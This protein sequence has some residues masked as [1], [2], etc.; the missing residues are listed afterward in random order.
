MI[1]EQVREADGVF[2]ARSAQAEN[3][4]LKYNEKELEKLHNKFLTEH[5]GSLVELDE[6]DIEEV[7]VK[8]P[9][10]EKT[11]EMLAKGMSILEIAEAREFSVDTIIGHIEKLLELKEDV[12]LTHTL[13]PKKIV[14]AIKKAFKELDT[15]K[16]TPVYE[17]LKGK[18]SYQDIRIVRATL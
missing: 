4:I 3:A 9:S 18:Y 11:K 5:G 8:V 17:H 2:R 1:A 10:H 14:D 7:E 15:R 6:E 13:P 12:E 16:L